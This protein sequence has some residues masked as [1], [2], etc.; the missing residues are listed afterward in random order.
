M[1]KPEGYKCSLSIRS[2]GSTCRKD[3]KRMSDSL[4]QFFL[5]KLALN[6][7]LVPASYLPPFIFKF[8]LSIQ[9]LMG[10]STRAFQ[11]FFAL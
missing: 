11:N 5:K 10:A 1:H 6:S 2:K 7:S 9:N 8:I 4:F 3:K